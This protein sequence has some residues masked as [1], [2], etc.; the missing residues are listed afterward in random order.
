MKKQTDILIMIQWLVVLVALAVT[1]QLA[2]MTGAVNW[3][4]TV[5][6]GLSCLGFGDACSRALRKEQPAAA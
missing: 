6:I 3:L 5:A 1:S 2:R 4:V